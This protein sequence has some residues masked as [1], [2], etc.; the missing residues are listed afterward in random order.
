MAAKVGSLG[1]VRYT[2]A[3]LLFKLHPVVDKSYQATFIDHLL[4]KSWTQLHAIDDLFL[5]KF[6]PSAKQT[7]P[8]KYKF[9]THLN[10]GRAVARRQPQLVTSTT[11]PFDGNKFNFNKIKPQELLFK[12]SRDDSDCPVAH[13]IINNSPIEYCS[14]LMVIDPEKCLPQRLTSSSLQMAIEFCALGQYYRLGFNSLGA[15]ASVNHCHWHVYH[16][17]D[18]LY[19]QSV[20]VVSESN[21]IFTDFPLPGF[22]FEITSASMIPQVVFKVMRLVDHVYTHDDQAYNLFITRN[23]SNDSIRVFI[24]IRKASFGLKNQFKFNPAFLELSGFFNCKSEQSL[25]EI[26]QNFCSQ[27]LKSMEIDSLDEYSN[28]LKDFSLEL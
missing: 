7:I 24:W 14:S 15:E 9:L 27:L 17:R 11:L 10:V 19:L 1:I 16:Q 5:Y 21:P 6:N 25:K 23:E 8:G 3:N 4:E 2:D 28:L 22:M 18:Y 13:I 26:D 12:V 20:S